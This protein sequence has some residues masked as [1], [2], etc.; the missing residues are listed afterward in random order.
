MY[1]EQLTSTQIYK[2]DCQAIS[3]FY[4]INHF[5]YLKITPGGILDMEWRYWFQTLFVN[6]RNLNRILGDTEK[7]QNFRKSN[8]K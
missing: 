5:W 8:I 6:R 4:S 3:S 2:L 7:I 1:D